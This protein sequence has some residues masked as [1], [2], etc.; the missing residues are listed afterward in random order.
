MTRSGGRADPRRDL[1]PG[2]LD[3]TATRALSVAYA[4][5]GLGVASI[6]VP[7][8]PGQLPHFH[9]P[10]TMAALAVT[11]LLPLGVLLAAPVAPVGALRR[12]L[13]VAGVLGTLTLWTLPL[14]LR[15]PLVSLDPPWVILAVTSSAV[16]M[17]IAG[18]GRTA[19]ALSVLNGLAITLDRVLA[20][21][22]GLGPT[23]L[24]DGAWSVVLS[25]VIVGLVMLTQQAIRTV[26]AATAAARAELREAAHRQVARDDRRWSRQFLHDEVLSVLNL[27]DREDPVL[28]DVARRR[29]RSALITLTLASPAS[30][31]T[32]GDG[33]GV[34][35]RELL[36]RVRETVADIDPGTTMEAELHDHLVVPAAVRTAVL[37]ALG[38]ALRNSLRHAGPGTSRRLRVRADRDE[39][40][41][42]LEDDGRGFD[43]ARVG[44]DRLGMAESVLAGMRRLPGGGAE[45]RSA[46]D[47]GTTVTLTWTPEG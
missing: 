43:P 37:A 46:P 29:A 32:T 8:I 21:P 45:V 20:G 47:R 30:P 15:T 41:L 31:P 2:P 27:A 39:L 24:R 44:A 9:L 14:G 34:P 22:P 42:A 17:A 6:Y 26:D 16:A 5:G 35:A 40:R 33:P 36:A 4:V 23:A 12:I 1:D 19:W 10:W 7:L 13:T 18:H 3:P 25:S 28:R 11:Y 38:E